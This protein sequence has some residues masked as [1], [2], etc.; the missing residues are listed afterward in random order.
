MDV[1]IL[2]LRLL[3][4][5]IP[6]MATVYIIIGI[7]MFKR[8]TH[9]KVNYFSILMFT[10]AIYSFGYFLEL[11]T[12][13]YEVLLIV[14]D[15]EFLGS[16][17]IP[18][19]G[20]PFVA[21]LTKSNLSKKL[22]IGF[23]AISTLLWLT[24]IT[25]P[26]H[27]FIYASVSSRDVKGFQIVSTVREPAFYL[28]MLYFGVFIILSSGMLLKAYKKSSKKK[29]KNSMRFLLIAFQ[30]PW[31]TIIFILKGWDAYI[32]P[33]SITIMIM[34]CFFMINE[35]KNDMFELQ[36]KRWE[37]TFI[38]IDSPAFL[39]NAEGELVGSNGSANNLFEQLGKKINDIMVDIDICYSRNLPVFIAVNHEVRW[40][41]VNKNAFDNRNRF[42]NYL[43]IDITDRKRAEDKLRENEK[44]FHTFFETMDDMIMVSNSDGEIFYANG[45]VSR[46]LGYTLGELQGMH[47][48]AVYPA[49]KRAE[50]SQIFEEML[51]GKRDVCNL[52]LV[53]K[54]GSFLPIETRVWYGKWDDQP[55]VFS[56]TKDLSIQ[57]AAL[58]KFHQL[59]D[60]NPALMAVSS[61]PER[62]FID[63]NLAFLD[64]LGF[65]KEE[66][67]G[68]TSNELDIFVDKDEQLML[69]AIQEMGVIKN[70]EMKI[71]KKDGQIMDGLFSGGI[72]DNQLEQSLLSVMTDVS[73]LKRTEIELMGSKERAEAA[74]IAKSQFLAN[75]SHEIRTP[76]NGIL[77]FLELLWTTNPSE[78]QMDYIREAKSASKVLLHLINDILDFS[79]IEAGKLIIEE[80]G[81]NL[82][83]MIEDTVSIL[84]PKA[85]HKKLELFTMI[86]G[87]VPEVVLGDPARI[88]QILNNLISN[89]LKFTEQG[90]VSVTVDC[91]S[92]E[93]EVALLLFEVKDQGIGISQNDISKL[94]Q[95]FSQADAST[96]RKYGGS[97]LGLAISKELV[98]IMEGNIQVESEVGKGSTFSFT[99]PLK[100]S[101]RSSVQYAEL[102][103]LEGINVLIIAQQLSSRRIIREYLGGTFCNVFEAQDRQ[104][105]LNII[106]SNVN[107]INKI[108]VALVD[109]EMAELSSS[110]ILKD[111]KLIL[112]TSVAQKGDVGKAKQMGFSGYLVKPIKR[113]DL[114]NCIAIVLE[115]K[116]NSLDTDQIVT[117]YTLKEVEESLKPKILLVED[118]EAN[119]KL[120]NIMLKNHG[121][122]C[123]L[124]VDG[125]EAYLA[126]RKKDYDLVFMDCQMP[127]MD[128]YQATAQIRLDAGERKHT[129][130]IAMTANAMEGDRT[131]CIE[132]GMDD[133]ISKPIHF[134]T[135][136][137]MIEE[138]TKK[139][140]IRK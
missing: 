8:N 136:F 65:A 11:N 115:L 93:N 56:V 127:I 122:S 34:C 59:F 63:V 35:I 107:T 13:D 125:K 118:K 90:E 113:D 80:I 87:S 128:G 139:N 123:D 71:R 31:I 2:L 99:L 3:L 17:F 109:Y 64:K 21:E 103:K 54:D 95:S 52:P 22:Q 98:E 44:N 12:T 89:A 114:L 74:N 19:A 43:L 138:N 91:I 51:A 61:L 50:V 134:P 48:L 6:I 129:T 10:S 29:S 121:Y 36:I 77:G 94:F 104:E 111:V 120:I 72:I 68:K 30:T 132:A 130:I 135:M 124:A 47:G 76:M 84:T 119:R 33:V 116:N 110:E 28:L 25:N 24:F 55:C 88:R 18:T 92:E 32:D 78:V 105:A 60:S 82:R 67:I 4:N 14:R 73:D 41:E 27:H 85:A 96:T 79:K 37:S 137:Q 23:F 81:F 112:L 46:K 62:R 66:V 49:E 40:F 86:K 133:Y 45:T 97:G 101:Q 70:V 7:V 39:V 75:M 83:T 53:R 131:K 20:I 126:V 42:E 102:A 5:C 106:V 15:F 140:L 1:E 58:D 108:R 100:I 38:R 9:E 16:V 69:S 117:G 57:Q 26:I